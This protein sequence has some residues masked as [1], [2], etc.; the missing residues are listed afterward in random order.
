VT[1]LAEALAR[2]DSDL[3][4]YG[5]RWALVGG[6]AVAA[7]ASPARLTRDVD[8]AIAVSGD[9]EAESLV[10][11]LY[12]RGYVTEAVLEQTAIGRLATMRL[13]SPAPAAQTVI[14]DL[15]FASSGIEPEVVDAASL[16]TTL[17]HRI[18]VAQLGHL[19]A[20][21]VL[22]NR[23]QD[24][25]DGARLILAAGEEEMRRARQALDLIAERGFARDQERDLQAELT[26]W[27]ERASAI[28]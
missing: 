24:Q 26:R 14:V 9:P 11:H 21:K 1:P 2:I 18:P 25:M 16:I 6:L 5:C 7:R 22:A 10:K 27:I 17:G 28:A 20:M 13:V 19:L 12:R 23:P 15:L 8:V 4:E 3:R